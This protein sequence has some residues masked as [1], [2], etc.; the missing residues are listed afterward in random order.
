MST[1]QSLAPASSSRSRETQ[2]PFTH[3]TSSW[4]DSRSSVLSAMS[5]MVTLWPSWERC[6]AT[7]PPT[8]PAPAMMI[9]KAISSFL[10]KIFGKRFKFP[11][12]GRNSRPAGIEFDGYSSTAPRAAEVTSLAYR[13]R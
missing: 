6:S 4:L 7:V 11:Q 2:F 1:S 8:L 9:F 12:S 3:I 10:L 13:A 5:T